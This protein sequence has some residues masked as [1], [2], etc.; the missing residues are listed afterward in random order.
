MNVTRNEEKSTPN[1][2]MKY[3]IPHFLLKKVTPYS[4]KNYSQN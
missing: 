1:S 2:I 3:F 4:E